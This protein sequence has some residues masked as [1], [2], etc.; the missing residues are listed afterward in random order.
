MLFFYNIFLFEFCIYKSCITS[1]QLVEPFVFVSINHNYNIKF[2]FFQNFITLAS[3][4]FKHSCKKKNCT[5]FSFS[6]GCVQF[7]NGGEL[8]IR[9]PG[10][11]HINGFQDRRF[12]PLSQ[13]STKSEI[14][15]LKTCSM[16][17]G[18]R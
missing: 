9:T 7:S 4:F 6:R 5:H 16:Q 13:L 1:N 15:S 12:R 10:Y 3:N 14:H 18:L 8:G 17:K 11:F 2:I